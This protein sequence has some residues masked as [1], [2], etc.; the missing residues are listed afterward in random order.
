MTSLLFALSLWMYLVQLRSVSLKFGVCIA[1]IHLRY[2]N[3][4]TARSKIY[5]YMYSSYRIPP[6]TYV[7]GKQYRD[8]WQSIPIN[9]DPEIYT[10]M[11][12]PTYRRIHTYRTSNTEIPGNQ[13]TH[14]YILLLIQTCHWSRHTLA[15]TVCME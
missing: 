14:Q 6:Y 4:C 10:Y 11:L 15:R 7:L 9:T 3:T 13:Y 12:I 8:T 5:L 1:H 2:I